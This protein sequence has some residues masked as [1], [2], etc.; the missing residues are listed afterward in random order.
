MRVLLVLLLAGSFAVAQQQTPPSP[1][2]APQDNAP[3]VAA[4]PADN[5]EQPD[6]NAN[7]PDTVVVPA[8]TK[9]PLSLQNPIST[10]AAK[11]GDPVYLQTTFPITQNDEMLIPAGTY[12]QG[13]ITS[14]KR[15]GRV[16]GRAELLMHF[17]TMVFPNGYTVSFPGAVDSVPGAENSKIKDKE[18]TVEHT[19][20]KGKDIGTVASTGATG[21]LI[22][23]AAGGGKGAL[24]GAAAGGATGLAIAML[25]RGSD[26][27]FET[28][29]VIEMVLQRPL[30]LQA[31]RLH[32]SGDQY[33][34]AKV[35]DQRLPKPDQGK[36]PDPRL[37]RPVLM[38]PPDPNR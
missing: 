12:V 14:V 34:P 19:S 10:K 25:T 22:G 29:T 1:E 38:P 35:P 33:L 6:P 36:G 30:T 4:Q 8:G 24:L 16:S 15:P 18:G 13:V 20:E 31:S 37:P 27:R 17:T 2:P 7:A 32:R 26:V 3:A 28:G 9:I 11:P 23:A 5:A 21:G